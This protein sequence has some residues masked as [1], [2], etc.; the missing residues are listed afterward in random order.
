MGMV[1]AA[2]I[3]ELQ[4]HNRSSLCLGP[5]FLKQVLGNSVLE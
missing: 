3:S 2:L 4:Q 5:S 1:E